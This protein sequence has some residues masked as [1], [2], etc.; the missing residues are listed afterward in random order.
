[1]QFNIYNIDHNVFSKR[2]VRYQK[3]NN[4]LQVLQR[5]QS[6]THKT[7]HKRGGG[8]TK[9]AHITHHTQWLNWKSIRLKSGRSQVK[10][11]TSC[12][13]YHAAFSIM[14]TGLGVFHI[15]QS[16]V[17]Q[18]FT[19]SMLKYQMSRGRVQQYLFFILSSL[20]QTYRSSDLQSSIKPSTT[21]V[22]HTLL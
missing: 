20:Q 10:N 13:Q 12:F 6:H 4:K 16:P 17:Y 7:P 19:P 3:R 18:H 21:K 15:R 22:A 1:M 2:W 11:G 8:N 14:R 5:T 9:A